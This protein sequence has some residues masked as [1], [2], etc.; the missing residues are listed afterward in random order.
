MPICITGMHRSGTSMVARLLNICGLYL[1]EQGEMLEANTE[2][3]SGFWEHKKFTMINESILINLN[4][5]GYTPFMKGW[6]QRSELIYFKEKA[7][8]LIANHVGYEPWGWKDPR[9]CMTLPFW[10]ELLPDIK[11]IICVRNPIEVAKSLSKRNLTME[12]S[13]NSWFRLNKYL[14]DN[15]YDMEFIITHFDS[16]FFD[17]KQELQRILSFVGISSSKE[18]IAHACKTISKSLRH[19]SVQKTENKHRFLTNEQLNLYNY[20]CKNAGSVFE[21]SMYDQ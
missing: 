1:G 10:K 17:S 4:R 21:R 11:V 6:E 19:H 7:A 13:F 8:N 20:L 5:I 18:K 9:N 16:Y 2:N 12:F 14:L 3:M 15:L